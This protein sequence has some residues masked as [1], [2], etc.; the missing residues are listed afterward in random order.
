MNAGSRI[1]VSNV[2]RK[3]LAAGASLSALAWASAVRAQVPE[4]KIRKI[5]LLSVLSPSN[6]YQPF[7]Q[8]LRDLGW[9]EG[10]NIIIEQRYAQGISDRLTELAAELVRRKVDVIVALSPPAAVAAQAATTSIPIVTTFTGDPVAGGRVKSLARPGGNVTGFSQMVRELAGKRLE[11]LKEMVP[12]L[13]RV[14]VLWDPTSYGYKS[15]RHC[16]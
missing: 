12:A 3:L 6:S 16:K 1:L 10:K 15:L 5:G 2:R 4:N 14:A 7:R 11:L 9:I 13:Q 8:S